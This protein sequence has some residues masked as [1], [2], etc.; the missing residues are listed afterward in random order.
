MPVDGGKAESPTVCSEIRLRGEFGVASAGLHH[1]PALFRMITIL[2]QNRSRTIPLLRHSVFSQSFSP[3]SHRY[4]FGSTG[5]GST[6]AMLFFPITGA[7]SQKTLST[8]PSSA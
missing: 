7:T 6:F 3:L 5:E 8:G 4:S 1:P 2:L